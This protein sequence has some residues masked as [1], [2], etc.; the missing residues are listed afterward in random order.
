MHTGDPEVC[1]A[2]ANAVAAL[3]AAAAASVAVSERGFAGGD[4]A[5]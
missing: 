5:L 3:A 2:L 4:I 1:V